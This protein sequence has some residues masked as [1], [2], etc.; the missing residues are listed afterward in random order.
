M[1]M[2]GK[3]FVLWGFHTKY[4]AFPSPGTVSLNRMY[5]VIHIRI[6]LKILIYV[7]MNIGNISYIHQT[8]FQIYQSCHGEEICCTLCL[9]RFNL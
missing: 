6:L 1:L 9:F 7:T 2:T 3:T 8:Y 5:E 4:V